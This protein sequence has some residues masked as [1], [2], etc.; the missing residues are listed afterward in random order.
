[1]TLEDVGKACGVSPQAVGQWEKNE[2][3][4]TV[5]KLERLAGVL[6]MTLA[7]LVSQEP[8]NLAELAGR[9]ES[10]QAKVAEI[11]GQQELERLRAENKELRAL[12]DRVLYMIDN[13]SEV[14]IEIRR[15]LKATGN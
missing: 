13:C 15:V 3:R 2:A 7:Q 10:A 9:L 12:V 8:P 4:P 6:E 11:V 14:A 5:D 1:M